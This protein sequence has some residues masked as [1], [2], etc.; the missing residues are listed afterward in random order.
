MYVPYEEHAK[1]VVCP[2]TPQLYLYT[3]RQ[4]GSSAKRVEVA[5]VEELEDEL[6]KL[7]ERAFWVDLAADDVKFDLSSV[8]EVVLISIQSPGRPCCG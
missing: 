4:V 5:S 2:T 7:G 8:E 3:A 1:L 6:A